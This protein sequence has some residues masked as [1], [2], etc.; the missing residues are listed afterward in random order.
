VDSARS[1]HRS[2]AAVPEGHAR[3]IIIRADNGKLSRIT[4]K[5]AEQGAERYQSARIHRVWLDEE[6]PEAVW[7]EMQPR[8]LRHGG[9]TLATMTPLKGYTWVHG[10]VYEPAQTGKVSP[11]AI[12]SR[13]RASK[14]N[15]SITPAALD[16]LEQE[17]KHNPS[18]LAAR[19]DGMFVRPIGAVWPFDLKC[20]ASS[21]P[22]SRCGDGA[23]VHALPRHRPGEVA[24]LDAVGDDRPRPGADDRRRDLLAE[25]GHDTRAKAM[26]DMLTRT[27]CRR[28]P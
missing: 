7:D 20:T 4:G 11:I 3:D 8:L 22:T 12:G 6:H 16:E 15:P 5:A 25:R 19:R 27:T 1:H 28:T 24:A 23:Q 2:A 10:R 18:Q 21:S 17:L 14:D 13:T 9:D 26:H